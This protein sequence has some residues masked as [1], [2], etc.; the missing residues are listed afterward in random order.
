MRDESAWFGGFD[1]AFLDSEKQYIFAFQAEVTPQVLVNREFVAENDLN[2]IKGFLDPN[3]KVRSPSTIP[4]VDGAGNGRIALWTGQLGEEFVRSLLRQDLTLSRD[5]R[6]LADWLARGRYPI[7]IGVNDTEIAELQKLGVGAKVEP[8]GG[9]VAEAWRL[10]TGWGAVRLV[11]KAPHINAATVFVNWLLSKDGQAAWATMVS[12]PSR[13]ND[14]AR[15]HGMSPEP[16]VDYF[17]IDRE[18]RVPLRDK[19]QE[20]SKLELR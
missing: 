2:S 11:N 20:I 6:Q 5:D 10:S 17:D 4:S 19:A 3:G 7:A 12:R 15:V 16:G 9:K 13:R 14:V 18:E 1:K 8:L